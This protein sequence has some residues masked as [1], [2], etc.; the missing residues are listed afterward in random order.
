MILSGRLHK[1]GCA[2]AIF[3][4]AVAKNNCHVQAYPAVEERTVNA[5]SG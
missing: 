5:G 3:F 2:V 4:G 1:T